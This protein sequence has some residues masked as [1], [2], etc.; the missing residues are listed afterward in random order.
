MTF[1]SDPNGLY[2]LYVSHDAKRDFV[3]KLTDQRESVTG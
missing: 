2:I 3:A 1:D